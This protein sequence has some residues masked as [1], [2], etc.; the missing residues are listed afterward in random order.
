MNIDAMPLLDG[1]RI[2]GCLFALAA[3]EFTADEAPVNVWGGF[4]CDGA[5]GFKVKV[6]EGAVDGV[7]VRAGG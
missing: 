5:R 4:E 1:M 2:R 6:E 7:E 3:E